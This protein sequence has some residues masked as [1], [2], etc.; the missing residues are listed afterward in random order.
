MKY[1][2]LAQGGYG[3]IYIDPTRTIICKRIPKQTTDS[4]L[5]YSTIVELVVSAA[6]QSF[7]GAP[8]VR[9]ID[10]E[11]EHAAIYMSYHGHT[12][13]RWISA[14]GK[15]EDEAH[16]AYSIMRS[17]VTILLQFKALNVMHTDIKPCNILLNKAVPPR[18][19][20]ID[21]NCAS[22]AEVDYTN[23]TPRIVY[24]GAMATYNFAA[25]ELVFEGQPTA[26][27]C[28][29]SLALIAC[30]LFGGSYPI[31]QNLTHDKNQQWYNTQD[32]WKDILIKL[33][34]GPTMTIPQSILSKMGSDF[35]LTAWVSQAFSWEPSNRP[36]LED[37]AVAIMGTAM[38]I[39][40]ISIIEKVASP[41]AL[42]RELRAHVIE[43]YY[44]IAIDTKKQSWFSTAVFLLDAGGGTT[45]GAN[46]AY[47]AACWVMS[48]CLH[49][50]YVL[51]DDSQLERLIYYF[52][53]GPEVII[54]YVWKIGRTNKWNLWAR[55]LDVVLIEDHGLSFSFDQIKDIMTWIDRPWTPTSYASFIALQECHLKR[56]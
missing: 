33:Q 23:V 32:E 24:S 31:T 38:P 15:N 2:L 16:T 3:N 27:S 35:K 44:N 55:P 48:G 14:Y 1:K 29:W 20:L 41:L 36:T 40:R 53:E 30:M 9:S 50:F 52:K 25:P 8:R 21:Y 47:A 22:V 42:P 56:S 39:P 13:N 4:N 12:L 19:I 43:R 28:V 10:I 54:K 34:H 5:V 49:N 51:D 18:V 45:V 7:A 17:L 46:F 37:V 6:T 11:D 26:T